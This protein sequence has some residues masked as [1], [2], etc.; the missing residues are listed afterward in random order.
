MDTRARLPKPSTYN[1]GYTTIID[2]ITFQ[3]QLNRANRRYWKKLVQPSQTFLPIVSPLPTFV[4]TIFS[5]L[6]TQPF[7]PTY[8][9]P[10]PPQL[11]LP[12]IVSPPPTFLPTYAS[13]PPIHPI[14]SPPPIQTFLPTY[15]SP[16]PVFLPTYASPTV[17]TQTLV[18]TYV[19]PPLIQPTK[20]YVSSQREKFHRILSQGVKL[21][22]N[23]YK[24]YKIMV[25]PRRKEYETTVRSE[26]F[27]NPFNP[28]KPTTGREI[29]TYSRKNIPDLPVWI[30]QNPNVSI[31]Y[32]FGGVI[33]KISI[34]GEPIIDRNININ[35]VSPWDYVRGSLLGIKDYQ[36]YEGKGGDDLWDWLLNELRGSQ[37]LVIDVDASE[38]R[39]S[40]GTYGGG[41][42]DEYGGYPNIVAD[43]SKP[44]TLNTLL[45]YF[46]KA[47]S[48]IYGRVLEFLPVE[49]E[50][51]MKSLNNLLKPKGIL[52]YLSYTFS[53]GVT[54]RR[55]DGKIYSLAGN[56][57]T[58]EELV[59]ELGKILLSHTDKQQLNIFIQYPN[60]KHLRVDYTLNHAKGL[61]EQK[62]LVKRMTDSGFSNLL[63]FVGK[64]ARGFKSFVITAQKDKDL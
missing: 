15:T 27:R 33:P 48:I 31:I 61:A 11:F 54:Y 60:I 58:A 56:E 34:I 37:I 44:G 7:L 13:P 30:I 22:S 23:E 64:S 8:T 62:N 50:K 63:Y 45:K 5:P 6:P 47:D 14:L 3:V 42:R 17:P 16:P 38:S 2:G 4:P 39:M 20:T 19:S 40:R 12:T 18:P 53:T 51:Y 28:F 46:G 35:G 24:I 25:D 43:I 36:F 21:V 41:I 59:E 29:W 52:L 55:K 1:A 49:D 26:K 10:P 32:A 9:S 57:L